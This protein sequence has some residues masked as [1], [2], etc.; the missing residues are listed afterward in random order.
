VAGVGQGA[1]TRRQLVALRVRKRRR[2]ELGSD[3]DD[4]LTIEPWCGQKARAGRLCQPR[5][6]AMSHTERNQM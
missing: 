1:G 6:M 3:A 4:G 2:N 5:T